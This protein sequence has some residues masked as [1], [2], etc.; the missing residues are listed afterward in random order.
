[1]GN[2]RDNSSNVI[3]LDKYYTTTEV[4]QYCIDV[5]Q[6]V[7]YHR[8]IT[9][10]VEPA[11]GSGSFSLL[12]SGCL[13]YDIE[14]EHPSI[15]QRD[16]FEYQWEY[17]QGRLWIGNPPFG[18]RCHLANAFF[19]RCSLFGDYIAFIMPAAQYNNSQRCYEFDLIHSELLPKGTVF[20][21]R[22]VNTCFNVYVRPKEG[23]YTGPPRYE[24]P[25]FKIIEINKGHKDPPTEYDLALVAWGVIG[26]E[27]VRGQEPHANTFY[28]QI[29][30]PDK[31]RIINLLREAD[32]CS[33]YPQTSTPTLHQWQ[34]KKYLYERI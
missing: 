23:P 12:L 6:E 26:T 4:A 28:F 32:W 14:P 16:F 17:K 10:I 8:P 34:V 33:I 15:E 25:G 18:S 1:M 31:D 20:T 29:D 11:A 30:R 9:E 3:A 19:K 21:D 22:S 13:A 7:L 2:V 24:I 27:E 5:T